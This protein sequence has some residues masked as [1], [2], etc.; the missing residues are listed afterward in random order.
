MK[1][2]AERDTL[3]KS[4]AAAGRAAGGGIMGDTPALHLSLVGD[5]LTT[6]G[7]DPDLTIRSACAV[8]GTKDGTVV[9]PAR[10]T[11]EIVKS[12]GPGAVVLTVADDVAITSGRAEFHVRSLDGVT[13]P[14]HDAPEGMVAIDAVPFVEGLRQ[15]VRAA[16]KDD[17]RAP[18]L[19]GVLAVQTDTGLRLVATDSYRLAVKD[20]PGITAVSDAAGVILPSRALSEVQHL[21]GNDLDTIAFGSTK[22]DAVFAIDGTTLTTRLINGQYP[23]YQ[24]LLPASYPYSFVA[25]RMELLEA[26]KRVR[27]I[28]RDAKDATTPV[29]LALTDAGMMIEVQIPE[30]GNATDIV[31][32]KFEGDEINVAFNPT[33]LIDGLDAVA[34]DDV[35]LQVI[36]SV[37]PVTLKG[38]D[39]DS[40]LYLLMPV[41]VSS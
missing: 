4:I 29:R 33:Y 17:S 7:A 15:V 28:I 19:T 27:V 3:L 35:V 2:A 22:L 20:I 23:D 8:D 13:L 25:N 34:T 9:V 32:G 16:L 10:L 30:T 26:I 39:D 41:K 38:V 11:I 18:T 37:K 40:Y 14:E 6:R 36:N 1:F 5:C 24:R 31:N 12:F 21:I